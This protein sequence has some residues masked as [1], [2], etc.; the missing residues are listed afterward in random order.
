[1]TETDAP[2][3]DNT[4]PGTDEAGELQDPRAMDDQELSELPDPPAPVEAPVASAVADSEHAGDGANDPDGA[5][6]EEPAG[7]DYAG[8]GF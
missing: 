2:K 3:P 7:E 4:E 6:R 1:M 8:S 5:Q